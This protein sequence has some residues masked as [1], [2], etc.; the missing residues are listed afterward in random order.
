[1]LIGLRN[2][3]KILPMQVADYILEFLSSQG[4]KHVFLMTGGA[5]AFVVDAFSRRKD[6]S[7]IC[8]AH[9]QAAAM[10]AEAYSRM[11]PGFA[12]AM[13]TSGPGATNL[14]TGIACAWFDSI[15]IICITGQ[16]NTY[17]QKGASG[18]RQIGFQETEIV[19][20]VKPI[21]KFA[22]QLDKAENI[23]FYLEK[24]T[25]IAKSGRPGPVLLDLP[26][27]YQRAEINPAEIAGFNP[28]D[29]LPFTDT[30]VELKNKIRQ[31]VDILKSAERPVI[32]VGG[33]IRLAKADKEILTLANQLKYPL[34]TSWSG[35]DLIPR[36]HPLYLGAQGVYGER[37]ANFAVQNSD[38]LLSIGSRLD[39]RQTGG[40]VATY[41]R[42]A[43]VI[44]IDADRAELDKR[45]GLTPVLTINS[46]AK[47][48]LTELIKALKNRQLPT[49]DLWLRKSLSWR[50]KYPNVQKIYYQEKK[51]VNPY[52]FISILS[53]ELDEKAVIITD[54]GANLT[55]TMQAFAVKQGQRLFSAFG[56]SPMGYSFPASIGASIALGKKEII[57]IDGDG[58]FQINLQELTTLANYKLPV[59]IF[60]LNNRGYGI[61]KQF[62]DLYLEGRHEATGK[63]YS[64]PD[65]IKLGKAY[66]IKTFSINSNNQIRKVIQRVL[67]WK[68]PVICDIKIKPRQKLIPK[69]E[70]GKPI[71]DLS[72]LLS[73]KEFYGNM[74][75]APIEQITAKK[76]KIN[77]IN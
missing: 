17:E 60:I 61:I 70:F 38:V 52:V 63:G 64:C 69:L 54:E 36:N 71:E 44:M 35:Y 66:D 30:G 25:Y 23:R 73:R 59:K 22:A 67:R 15:P 9:E 18:V 7:Y 14:V 21:T 11:G 40:K 4:I 12:C 57:C 6:I 29:D 62:Q 68:G 51:Y 16:V 39:T 33:G 75:V 48:F 2:V 41:A 65:F 77:E 45:R 1:M 19:D 72:P 10:M 34:I 50:K 47:V 3:V 46:D 42:S 56:N 58:G 26:M 5:I 27:N 74:I 13:A 8:T 43:K 32:L 31:T 76:I 53:E 37:A 24:A 28:P 20:I 55:W 49:V